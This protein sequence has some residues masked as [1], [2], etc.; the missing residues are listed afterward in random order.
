M[1]KAAAYIHI[2]IMA[3]KTVLGGIISG[4]LGHV[5]SLII[6]IGLVSILT[7]FT[8][9]LLLQKFPRALIWT[10][11]V[12]L[13]LILFFML[14]GCIIAGKLLAALIFTILLAVYLCVLYA[15]RHR[16]E[17]TVV[18]VKLTSVFMFQNMSVYFIPLMMGLITMALAIILVFSIGTTYAME[19]LSKIS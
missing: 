18:L 9:F 5:I 4:F 10:S 16:L 2:P 19:K 11:L 13:G 15:F 12:I 3:A 17:A 1:S 8:F 7:S 14:V 6:A